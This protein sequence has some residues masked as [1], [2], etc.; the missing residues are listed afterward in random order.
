MFV[1]PFLALIRTAELV[2]TDVT[3]RLAHTS[4]LIRDE[5]NDG[6]CVG[7]REGGT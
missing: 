3:S 6:H 1:F 7:G 4:L 5:L 2:T